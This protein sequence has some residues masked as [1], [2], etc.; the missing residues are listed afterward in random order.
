M[1]ELLDY[2][3]RLSQNNCKSWFDSH[4]DEY[5][6]SKKQ[7]EA[8]AEQ[9][10]QG[11]ELFDPRCQGLTPKDCTY[12]INRDIRFSQ[13]KRPY[14]DWHGIYVCPR[15]KKSGM[16]GYYIHLEPA[17][18]EFFLCGGL[19]NPTR[20]VLQS[21]REQISLEPEE[22]H[23]AVLAC[24]QDFRLGWGH[25]LKRMPLGYKDTDP[26]SEYYRLRSY[27]ILCPLTKREV[28][29]KDFLNKA[30]ARLQK[31]YRL[32]EWLNRCYDY[33]CESR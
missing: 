26:H 17:N 1:K 19:Y 4:R 3:L 33:A 8:L 5:E 27:E 11:V 2:Y 21:V 28:L 14:K 15:G 24:G 30:V 31:C 10:I 6:K 22:F 9:F 13:D 7:L 20:E 29:E 25:A 32:N 18:N 23:Q 12:R 16:A